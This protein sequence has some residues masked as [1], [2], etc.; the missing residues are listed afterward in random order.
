MKDRYLNNLKIVKKVAKRF[1]Y[2]PYAFDP[3]WTLIKT[4]DSS[5]TKFSTNPDRT[6]ISDSFMAMLAL[7]LNF[8]WEFEISTKILKKQIQT[9]QEAIDYMQ[10][11]PHTTPDIIKIYQD[12]IDEFTS[13]IKYRKKF[14]EER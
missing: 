7:S 12:S 9:N 5:E 11:L 1:G 2:I 4:L 13:E 6:T 8:P 10:K 14:T 3:D